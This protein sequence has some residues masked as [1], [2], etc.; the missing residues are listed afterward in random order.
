MDASAL[1]QEV[2]PHALRIGSLLGLFLGAL[3]LWSRVFRNPRLEIG[4]PKIKGVSGIGARR[5]VFIVEMPVRNLGR[6]RC[7]RVA[8]CG[9]SPDPDPEPTRLSPASVPRTLAPGEE[10]TLRTEVSCPMG[11]D[12]LDSRDVTLHVW[13]AGDTGPAALCTLSFRVFK[14]NAL[15]NEATTARVTLMRSSTARLLAKVFW[16]RLARKWSARIWPGGAFQRAMVQREGYLR[17][18]RLIV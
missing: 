3:E 5:A 18:N 7:G 8:L 6:A 13:A 10:A 1:W 15:L 11:P 9:W 17:G 2:E 14:L 16:W 12:G 4:D